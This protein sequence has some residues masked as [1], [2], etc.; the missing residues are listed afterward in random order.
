MERQCS[1]RKE[2]K[3]RE[4][5]GRATLCDEEETKERKEK[6]KGRATGY[7]GGGVREREQD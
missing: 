4:G 5:E 6:E 7:E 2:K 1:E 3:I